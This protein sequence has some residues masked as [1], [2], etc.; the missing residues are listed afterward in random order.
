MQQQPALSGLRERFPP[1]VTPVRLREKD[2]AHA[3]A[4]A[5]AAEAGAGTIF[6][7]GRFDMIEFA[8]VLEPY[9]PLHVSRRALFPAMNALAET[10]AAECPP[11]RTIAFDYP[12]GL[13]FDHGLLGGG[14]LAWPE[15]TAEDAVPDWL[16]FSAMLRTG[17][18]QELGFTLSSKATTLEEAGYGEIDPDAFA[19]RF[20]KHLMV[21]LDDWVENGFREV[22]QRYL[23]RL[24]R[25]GSADTFGIDRS[26]DLMR[27]PKAG[28]PGVRRSYS[29]ALAAADW[30]DPATGEPRR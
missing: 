15:G 16:V 28:G 21:E 30:F 19:A 10:L 14:R 27:L 4:V 1:L 20:C 6:H 3:T 9:Q 7:V 2:D 13:L 23:A 25:G 12:G 24:E 17:G 8:V 29:E 26:G 5:R 18:F 11:E 22:G